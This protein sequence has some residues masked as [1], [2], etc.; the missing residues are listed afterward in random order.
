MALESAIF[1]Q[2]VFSLQNLNTTYY[3]PFQSI[4]TIFHWLIKLV[5]FGL[6]TIS[7][8]NLRSQTTL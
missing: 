5:S 6:N 1:K 7:I 8:G 3:E 2:K 4:S